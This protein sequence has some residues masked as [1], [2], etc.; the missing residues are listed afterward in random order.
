MSY[1]SEIWIYLKSVLNVINVFE[2]WCYRRILRI[3][4]TEHV[5]NEEV[6][7]MA[8]TK[9]TSLMDY[10]RGDWLSMVT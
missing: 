7:N 6:F 4:W 5:T 3:S 2:R 9:P 1:G 8:N 10:V